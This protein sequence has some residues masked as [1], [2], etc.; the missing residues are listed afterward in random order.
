MIRTQV[1]IPDDLH[2]DLMLLAKTSGLNF[3]QLIRE[4]AEEVKK[5]RA[6]TQKKRDWKKFIGAGGRGGPKDLSS[7]I[8]YYLYGEGNPK[9]AGR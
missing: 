9:W 4:G 7:K 2:R 6:K 5:K 1:Y 8:D 3:S